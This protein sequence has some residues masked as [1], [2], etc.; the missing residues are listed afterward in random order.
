MSSPYATAT[1][2]LILRELKGETTGMFGLEIVQSSGGELSRASVYTLLGRLED[3]GFV[4]SRV[5]RDTE[6]AGLKRPRYKL[7]GL[8]ER[9]LAAA[10]LMGLSAAKA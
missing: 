6:R 9:A 2:L 5:V 1:E 10:D 3:K 4:E 7:T 8:G